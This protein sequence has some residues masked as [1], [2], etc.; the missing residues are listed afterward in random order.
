MNIE[1]PVE[2]LADRQQRLMREGI[3]LGIVVA[4]ALLAAVKPSLSD[5]AVSALY[6][7]IICVAF[8]K[9]GE[10]AGWFVALVTGLATGFSTLGSHDT[11]ELGA[12]F[13]RNV[14]TIVR[15]PF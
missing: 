4:Y 11:P 13:A 15:Q 1:V 2:H 6:I 3:W 9:L 7:P 12:I 14:S 5:I 8:W 10:S